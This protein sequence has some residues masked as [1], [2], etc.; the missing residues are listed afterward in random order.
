[1]LTSLLVTI[2]SLSVR[3]TYMKSFKTLSFVLALSST[4]AW[5][6]TP[7]T[8]YV[9]GQFG[10]YNYNENNQFYQNVF[11]SFNP[12]AR[13]G[14]GYTWYMNEAIDFSVEGGY[15]WYS[16]LNTNDFDQGITS[17]VPGL[18]VNFKRH[19][20]DLLGVF[21]HH[22]TNTSWNIFLK[23]GLA[24]VSNSVNA[25]YTNV[26]LSA[27]QNFLTPKA[28]LGLGYSFN[29]KVNLNFSLNQEFETNNYNNYSP[30]ATS[31]LL[32]LNYLFI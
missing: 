3:A 28:A 31:W 24:F 10:Q 6:I 14:F 1:M 13:L 8:P 7:P 17:V 30:S 18:S 20:L 15:Q 2:P 12:T 27:S 5:A 11:D 29:E 9:T 26:T 4:T 32:G 23:A 25:S 19:S 22:F 16:N 21:G